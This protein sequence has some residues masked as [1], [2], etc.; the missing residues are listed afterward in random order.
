MF[1]V[2]FLKKTGLQSDV[3]SYSELIEKDDPKHSEPNSDF[4]QINKSNKSYWYYLVV[5]CV[6][7]FVS[8]SFF[9]I[10]NNLND[11]HSYDLLLIS[12]HQT[13]QHPYS[14]NFLDLARIFYQ[15]LLSTLT[16]LR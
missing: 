3:E 10:N 4:V 9:L 13:I 16:E 15:I 14:T 11:H 7:L 1:D 2:N 12:H 8:Y 6:L 5:M